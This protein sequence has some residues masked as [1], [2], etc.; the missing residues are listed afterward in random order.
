[1]KEISRLCKYSPLFNCKTFVAK[2]FERFVIFNIDISV[3][4]GRRSVSSIRL[5]DI[6]L[7]FLA[8]NGVC[9]CLYSTS[10]H[11]LFHDPRCIFRI[12]VLLQVFQR[13]QFTS[14]SFLEFSFLENFLE[15]D[16]RLERIDHFDTN[17][18]DLFQFFIK[19]YN[20]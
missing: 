3:C 20:F 18:Y 11:P 5:E 12:V 14:P 10:F 16:T 2:V 6:C 13:Y 9:I 1:M 17:P 4:L 7:I 15:F 8:H 19:C